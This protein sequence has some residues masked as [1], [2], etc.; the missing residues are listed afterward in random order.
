MIP[1]DLAEWSAEERERWFQGKFRRS[2]ERA[3][4]VHEV[5]QR[6]DAAHPAIQAVHHPNWSADE[7]TRLARFVN[8]LWGATDL[9][10]GDELGD[11]ERAALA[12]YLD[13]TPV[14][15]YAAALRFSDITTRH[16]VIAG[17]DALGAM[18]TIFGELYAVRADGSTYS[19]ARDGL[20]S[21]RGELSGSG[22]TTKSFRCAA[23]GAIVQTAGGQ[24]TLLGFAGEL[25]DASGL[26]YLRARWYDP[27][28]GRYMTRDSVA[29][30]AESPASMNGYGYGHGRPTVLTDPS[31]QCPR[32][33]S[34]SASARSLAPSPAGLLIGTRV[35]DEPIIP[36][37]GSLNRRRVPGDLGRPD[38]R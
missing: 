30:D 4:L 35:Q 13:L 17:G 2:W 5:Q 6:N 14:G 31:G 15:G 19:F 10:T 27:A 16:A 7:I 18:W 1:Q 37:Q 26:L 33:L 38:W 32:S 8:Y 12:A 25:S 3:Q 21:V 23:Y 28:V 22:S 11:E 36:R 34:A 9:R 29:G 20:G 24:P